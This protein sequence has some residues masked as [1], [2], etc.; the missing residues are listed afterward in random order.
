MKSYNYI[1]LNVNKWFIISI[2][3]FP[4]MRIK[5]TKS[6]LGAEENK[7]ENKKPDVE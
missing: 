5:L 6:N 2:F 7:E 1:K 4:S 3:A